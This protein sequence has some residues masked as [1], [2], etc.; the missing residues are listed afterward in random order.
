[1]SSGGLT[2]F[3]TDQIQQI[4]GA[5]NTGQEQWD[6]IW[7][8]VRANLNDAVATA[9]DHTT[10]GSLADRETQYHRLSNQYTQQV[11]TQGMAMNNIADTAL[12]YG[13][14]MARTLRG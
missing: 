4:R 3:N 14:Q 1:M 10:G 5:T 13:A 8:R 6:G 9:L 12:D 7:A 11:G 2:A